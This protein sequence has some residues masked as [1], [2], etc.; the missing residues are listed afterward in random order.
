MKRL[1]LA[2]LAVALLAAMAWPVSRAIG[3]SADVREPAVCREM[4]PE[5]MLE[6]PALAEEWA[7]ALRSAQPEEMARV[8]AMISQIRAAHG[9]TVEPEMPAPSQAPSFLPPGHPPIPGLDALPPGHPPVQSAPRLPRIEAPA[10][11]T[12]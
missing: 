4:T 8:R 10:V 6:L 1:P 9:C 12:I 11:L 3:T 2:L 5:R 7:Q